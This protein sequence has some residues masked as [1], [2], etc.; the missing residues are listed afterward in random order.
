MLLGPSPT[1]Q[2]N[3]TQSTSESGRTEGSR[4]LP[5]APRFGSNIHT[6][7]HDEDDERFSDRN[8]FRNGNS[9]EYG[10][11]DDSK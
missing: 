3:S 9:T 8:K 2:N 1:L 7:R 6:L 10:G 5:P 4:K 11:N